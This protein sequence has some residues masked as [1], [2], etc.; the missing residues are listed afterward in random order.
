MEN[1]SPLSREG[2][3]D[4]KQKLG[5]QLKTYHVLVAIV[6]MDKKHADNIS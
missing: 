5:L 6:T 2:V 4:K 1:E 3:I